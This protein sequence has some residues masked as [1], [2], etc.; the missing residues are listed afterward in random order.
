ME[1]R[2]VDDRRRGLYDKFSVLRI[3]GSS[4][5]RG[6][7]NNCDYFVLDLVHDRY[8]RDA[9]LAY[10]QACVGEYPALAE[11]LRSRAARMP[12][13]VSIIVNGRQEFVSSWDLTFSE[14]VALSGQ[15]V[16]VGFV[17]DQMPYATVTYRKGPS[18]KP[19]GSLVWGETVKVSDGM[20]FNVTRTDKSG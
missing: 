3:D 17:P 14:V 12:E 11:D 10:A 2:C 15:V 13:A 9:I 6:K 20:I 19:E 8:A 7:H 16:L 5:P 1:V 18:N 4:G